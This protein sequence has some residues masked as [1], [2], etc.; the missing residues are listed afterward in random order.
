MPIKRTIVGFAFEG[1]GL[2]L[3]KTG[4]LC[5]SWGRHAPHADS[6]Y[7]W[8]EALVQL[9]QS[10]STEVNP[11]TGEWSTSPF[12]LE[13][14]A[15]DRLAQLFLSDQRRTPYS[16][17][18]A[19]SDTNTSVSLGDTTLAGQLVWID[20]E[21]ILLGIHAGLGIYGGCTRG[22]WGTRGVAHAQGALAYTRI[23]RWP[24]RLVKLIEQDV[25]TG[26][27]TTRWRG[28][29]RD[30][31]QDRGAIIV[32]CEEYLSALA[33]AQI[34]RS[35][36]DLA[37][38]AGLRWEVFPAST[39]L[40]CS[41]LS[42]YTSS[43][44][45]ASSPSTALCT[46]E[47]DGYVSVVQLGDL[48]SGASFF[49]GEWLYGRRPDASESGPFD[50]SLWEVLVLPQ[51]LDDVSGYPQAHPL[52]AALALLT[53]TG[54][55]RNGAFDVLGASW[56]LGLDV[57]DLDVWTDAIALSPH[58]TYDHL[59]L[60]AG[61]SPCSVLTTV[62]ETLLKPFGYFLAQTVTGS[63]ALA[64][65]GLP[66]IADASAAAVA[67]VVPYPDGPLRLERALQSQAQ[68]VVAT[69]GGTPGTGDGRDLTLKPPDALTRAVQLG[70]VRQH[71]Y[72]LQALS[73]RRISGTRRT[74]GALVSA[75]ASL[76]SL[77]LDTVPRLK[78]RIGDHNVTSTP[79]PDMGAW[80][81]LA[82]LG[83]LQ[84]AWLV[85]AQGERVSDASGAEWI[86]MVIGRAWDLERHTYELTLLL[87][88]YRT[89]AYTRERAPSA[90]V[91]SWDLGTLTLTVEPNTFGG[92]S[93]DPETFTPGDEVRIYGRDGTPIDT[94]EVRT[95]VA[96]SGTTIQI[97]AAWT[98][99]PT[100]GRVIRLAYSSDYKNSTRYPI[101]IR[102]YVYM[103]SADEGGFEDGDGNMVALDVYG[104][105]VFGGV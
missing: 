100:A 73:P 23:P 90:V 9:P 45:P 65:L 31:N 28:L 51:L 72:D 40:R 70:D 58:L 83:P 82:S 52:T 53:S 62:Q 102:P 34:N 37:Q 48:R 78:V 39:S 29:V 43:T 8:V 96:V 60:G 6:D 3:D 85:N 93:S 66:T 77:G 76:L 94:G 91:S 92:D 71:R 13:I 67:S 56:G 97:N 68:E 95:V 99:A 21:C 86:G 64:R 36:R 26:E 98:T 2:D 30:I 84:D 89:G 101:T 81:S 79:A 44:R 103:G 17:A 1:V 12:T 46:V 4:G 10:V 75:L 16:L 5:V 27:E 61:G 105:S 80:L 88:A 59:V 7:E 55:G 69:V 18:L 41:G 33:R 25:D 54:T 49:V 19:L 22:Y 14:E 47:V 50:G 74:T 24:H 63:F 42:G 38:G 35:P 57:L 87:L 11:Y 15:S 32:E 104:S 20:D